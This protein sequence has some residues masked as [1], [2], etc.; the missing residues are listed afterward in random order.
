MFKLM[1][2]RYYEFHGGIVWNQVLSQLLLQDGIQ[3]IM[4][5][6]EHEIDNIF[7]TK[8]NIYIKR[9]KLLCVVYM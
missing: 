4:H 6:L 2:S 5:I 9:R 3:C 7:G 1:P 8:V